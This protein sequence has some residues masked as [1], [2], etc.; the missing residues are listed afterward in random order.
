[1]IIWGGVNGTNIFN[2]GA[3]YDPITNTW[4]LTTLNNA[5]T[6]R[7]SHTA[8]WTGTKM[9]I[10]GGIKNQVLNT[11]GIYYNPAVIG[12][13]KIGEEI[14]KGFWLYQNFP[15]PF[16]PTTKIKFYLPV[17]ENV[18]LKI[19]D[20]LGQEVVTIFNNELKEKGTYEIDWNGTRFASGV[21]FYRLEAGPYT[22]VKKMV[23]IK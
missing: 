14:P 6:P 12:I 8:V 4:Q 17:K 23:L 19:Y 9:I 3:I 10:W 2:E 5:P 18:T 13:N 7:K 16:N 20:V 15:N 22:E 21:Y 1:M 11:G